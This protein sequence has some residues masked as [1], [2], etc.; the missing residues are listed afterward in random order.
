MLLCVGLQVAEGL[1]TSW[2]REKLCPGWPGAG[3][4]ELAVPGGSGSQGCGVCSTGRARTRSRRRVL[5]PPPF[6]YHCRLKSRA[7]FP[8]PN[9]A[10][11][12]RLCNIRRPDD[13][14]LRLESLKENGLSL[15]CSRRC[16]GTKCLL[17]LRARGFQSLHK[18]SRLRF[19]PPIQHVNLGF[20]WS[21]CF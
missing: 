18:P 17:P 7:P 1:G 6:Y 5:G 8:I 11:P 21:L 14:L 10:F 13:K 20:L 12:A 9:M 4:R 16:F 2:G 15:P 3:P 19:P